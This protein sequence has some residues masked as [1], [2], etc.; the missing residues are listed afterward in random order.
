MCESCVSRVTTWRTPHNV[1]PHKR[2]MRAPSAGTGPGT[3]LTVT[4]PPD[5]GL[6]R[7][8]ARAVRLGA[9]DLL[10]TYH[11]QLGAGWHLD[12]GAGLRCPVSLRLLGRHGGTDGGRSDKD[13]ED[14][15]HAETDDGKSD[16]LPQHALARNHRCER[17]GY[18]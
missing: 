3:H 11:R 12:Q 14:S 8:D 13:R 17:G 7:P 5:L 18:G 6:E 15:N 9:H 16:Y 4:T 10:R 2:G 1:T